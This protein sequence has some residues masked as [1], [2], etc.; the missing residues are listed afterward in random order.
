M[1]NKFY[2]LLK[3]KYIIL[4]INEIVVIYLILE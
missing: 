1:N 2:I 4:K 3:L